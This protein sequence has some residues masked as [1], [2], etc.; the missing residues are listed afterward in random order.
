MRSL[1]DIILLTLIATFGLLFMSACEEK[2]PEDKAAAEKQE[3]AKAEGAKAD[4]AAASDENKGETA[5]AEPAA[6]P[7]AD[8]PAAEKVALV[9]QPGA[10]IGDTT[11]CPVMG[12]TFE[13][14]EDSTFADYN[15]Q[16]V[17]FCCGGCQKGFAEDP[18]GLLAA[19]KTKIDA[20]NAK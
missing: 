18:D 16:K 14:K 15:G 7:A 19:L 4:E 3:P 10:K 20:E 2:K 1:R 12:N 5:A 11:I 13:V 6:K 17:F 9:H 8:E